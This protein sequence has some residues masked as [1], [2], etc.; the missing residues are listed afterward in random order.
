MFR[1]V[2]IYDFGE[3]LLP[4]PGTEPTAVHCWTAAG[5]VELW[6]EPGACAAAAGALSISNEA[7]LTSVTV[8]H[9]N[10]ALSL[11]DVALNA[12]SS[13]GRASSV[14]NMN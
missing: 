10:V 4:A 11:S 6:L 14:P 8:F 3:L 1:S 5:A 2:K 9:V 7:L 12:A 13:I